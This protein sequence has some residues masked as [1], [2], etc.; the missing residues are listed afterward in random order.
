[1]NLALHLVLW[2]NGAKNKGLQEKHNWYNLYAEAQP[3]INTAT[4]YT[5]QIL[6]TLNFILIAT[7]R[8]THF[9]IQLGRF[10][11]PNM[12]MCKH[13][14][15]LTRIPLV[16]FGPTMNHGAIKLGP[17]VVFHFETMCLFLS[18]TCPDLIV[19]VDFLV[20]S[21]ERYPITTVTYLAAG[22]FFWFL[23]LSLILFCSLAVHSNVYRTEELTTEL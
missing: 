15:S 19:P 17:L 21:V 1:M 20:V 10:Y 11:T 18:S 2:W 3:L 13:M 22:F 16:S 12:F 6:T 23:S 7:P 9:Y 5:L 8:Q 14:G 4:H